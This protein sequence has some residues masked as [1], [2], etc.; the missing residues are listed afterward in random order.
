M[1]KWFVVIGLCA[2]LASC[3]S[4]TEKTQAKSPLPPAPPSQV[5]GKSNNPAAKYVELVGFRTREKGPGKIEL[6]FGV[7]NHSEA[8]LGDLTMKVE[9][10][11]IE[12]KP[13]DPAVFSFDAKVPALG[14]EEL[15]EVSV[16]VPS[17]MRVYELPDWQFLRPQ[18]QILEPK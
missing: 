4:D 1:R 2:F 5:I 7:V 11:T 10:R 13:N 14:P 15:K 17:K 6:S 3:S 9:L 18:F 8:D 12:S 16:V